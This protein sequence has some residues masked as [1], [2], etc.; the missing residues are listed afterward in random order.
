MWLRLTR[1]RENGKDTWDIPTDIEGLPSGTGCPW[2]RLETISFFQGPNKDIYVRD[3]P[4]ECGLNFCLLSDV[5]LGRCDPLLAHSRNWCRATLGS[6]LWF[7]LF[8]GSWDRHPLFLP[9]SIFPSLKIRLPFFW[10]ELVPAHS[11]TTFFEEGWPH[12]QFQDWKSSQGPR[13]KHTLSPGRAENP[14][15]GCNRTSPQSF[16][17]IKS[18]AWN[19]ESSLA[20]PRERVTEKGVRADRTQGWSAY[21]L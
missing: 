5:S 21:I 10:G 17:D 2:Q 20:V 11:Q 8:V 4:V 9:G 1:V 3:S 7:W 18:E 12:S 15:K 16:A 13:R 14:E 6:F 19:A